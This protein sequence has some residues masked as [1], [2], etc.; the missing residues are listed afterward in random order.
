MPRNITFSDTRTHDFF[1]N[2]NCFK[3]GPFNLKVLCDENFGLYKNVWQHVTSA[4]I[5][6][7]LHSQKKWGG[8]G[9]S[10]P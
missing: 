4:G 6:S 5:L 7:E 3:Y 2:P 9:G 10:V 8:G 1:R